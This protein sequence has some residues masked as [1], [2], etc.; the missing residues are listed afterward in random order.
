M[1]APTHEEL[2]EPVEAYLCRTDVTVGP[3]VSV[4]ISPLDLRE[5]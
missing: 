1:H 2:L 4:L 5:E 3:Y